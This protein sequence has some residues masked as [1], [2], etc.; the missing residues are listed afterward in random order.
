MTTKKGANGPITKKVN[1]LKNNAS[2]S[3]QETV[4]SRF[5]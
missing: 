2:L 3:H 5:N 4:L 1:K